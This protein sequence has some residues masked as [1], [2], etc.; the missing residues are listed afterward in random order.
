[1]RATSSTPGVFRL[2]FKVLTALMVATAWS[3]LGYGLV[4]SRPDIRAWGE[5]EAAGRFGM[6]FFVYMPYY[7]LSLPLVAVAIVSLFPRPDRMF[8]LAGAMGLTGLFAV[9]IL[10]NKL[11]LVA[12]PELAR[13]AIVGLGLTAAATVPLLTAHHLKAHPATT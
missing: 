9:W 13:Y 8:P 2:I 11:L 6:N 3:V 12:Q 5:L 10:A 4:F 1:M 7:A